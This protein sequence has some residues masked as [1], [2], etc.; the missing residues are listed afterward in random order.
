AAA[1]A[2]KPAAAPTTQPAPAEKPLAAGQVAVKVQC[3]GMPDGALKDCKALSSEPK[4]ADAE[5]AA[6]QIASQQKGKP[7]AD[8]PAEGR[9]LVLPLVLTPNK[10]GS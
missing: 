4:N 10:A 2:A 7:P 9:M 3:R 6:V 1:P 5:Q 8:W